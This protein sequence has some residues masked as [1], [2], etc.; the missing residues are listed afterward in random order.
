[1]ELRILSIQDHKFGYEFPFSSAK[2]IRRFA[3]SI[4]SCPQWGQGKERAGKSF[5]LPPV[6]ETVSLFPR[7]GKMAEGRG[8]PARTVCY[9]SGVRYRGRGLAGDNTLLPPNPR[10]PYPALRATFPPPGARKNVGREALVL[11]PIGGR[12][13]KE[14]IRFF[15]TERFIRNQIYELVH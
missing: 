8:V 9:T 1:M 2:P 13:L 10:T 6:G 7:S 5:F 12:G 4:I 11:V 3:G 14:A 15:C